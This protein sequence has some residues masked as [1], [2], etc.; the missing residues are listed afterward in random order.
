MSY[1]K[2]R[3]FYLGWPVIGINK[4][5]LIVTFSEKKNWELEFDKFTPWN[6]QRR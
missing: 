2:E 5:N 3:I 4:V 6:L 1:L